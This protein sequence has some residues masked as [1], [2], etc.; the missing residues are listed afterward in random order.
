VNNKCQK[1][2]HILVFVFGLCFCLSLGHGEEGI[3]GQA[4]SS[5]SVGSLRFEATENKGEYQFNTGI[6]QGLLRAKGKSRGLSAVTYLPGKIRIDGGTGLLGFYRNFSGK[7][8][9][10]TAL[11]DRASTSKLLANGAVQIHWPADKDNPFAITA[12]YRWVNASTMDLETQVKPAQDLPAFEVFLASYFNKEFPATSVLVKN[13]NPQHTPPA[14]FIEA[15]ESGGT[16][17]MYPRDVQVKS[18]ITD[19]RWEQNPHPVNWEIREFLA[20]PIG[21]RRHEP[22]GLKVIVMTRPQ[23]CFAIATPCKKETHYSL[24]FSLFGRDITKDKTIRAH[25]RLL[26]TPEISDEEILKQYQKFM[27]ETKRIQI[28]K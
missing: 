26:F 18:L 4:V 23:D 5:A 14:K 3:S 28:S 16:W 10:G 22:S 15:Q 21:L 24:Y 1:N 11:W 13:K 25:T 17:Q 19:G 7:T 20:A 2:L 12:I 8:R 27:R 6:V 9:F